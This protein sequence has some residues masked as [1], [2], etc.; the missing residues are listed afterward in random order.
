MSSWYDMHSSKL[1]TGS[2]VMLNVYLAYKNH[3]EITF[4]VR[5]K[6]SWPWQ[7]C[8]SFS[9]PQWQA[10]IGA[11]RPLAHCV[12]SLFSSMNAKGIRQRHLN[13]LHS[14]LAISLLW[15]NRQL[16]SEALGYSYSRSAQLTASVSAMISLEAS[17]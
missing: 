9:E 14:E 16:S 13:R 8:L 5:I 6:D 10:L 1:P 4:L 3:F 7:F 17:A 11:G 2:E 12:D 15:V